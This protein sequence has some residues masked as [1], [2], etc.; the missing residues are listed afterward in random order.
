MVLSIFLSHLHY[1]IDVVGAYAV[2]FSIYVL[3]EGWGR[4]ARPAG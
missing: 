3:R 2:A 1:S 4:E